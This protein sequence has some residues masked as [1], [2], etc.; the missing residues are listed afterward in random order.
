MQSDFPKVTQVEIEQNQ[1]RS[2]D[3][4]PRLVPLSHSCFQLSGDVHLKN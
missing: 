4:N 2:F 1:P 3:A